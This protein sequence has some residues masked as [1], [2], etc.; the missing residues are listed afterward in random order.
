MSEKRQ[1]AIAALITAKKKESKTKHAL[2]RKAITRLVNGSELLTVSSVARA[3]GVS[4]WLIYNTP[5]LK[6]AVTRA[7]AQQRTTWAQ[8]HEQAGM[9]PKG[10]MTE[11]LRLQE[12]LATVTR[13]RDHY[14]R[15]VNINLAE[16]LAGRTPEQMASYISELES[17]L[18]AERENAGKARQAI[19]ELEATVED[20]NDQLR[21]A[22]SINRTMMKQRNETA[23][24]T[25]LE[26]R[27][28]E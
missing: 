28:P 27:I 4:R 8:G 24:V 13:Q 16:A 14:K 21:A 18:T 12:R 1:A 2:V 25:R 26:P 3:A 19:S 11:L 6:T 15:A 7:A 5:E 22:Q 23:P 20:L 10:A 9:T 17:Q